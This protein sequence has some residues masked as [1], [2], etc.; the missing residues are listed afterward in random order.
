MSDTAIR[1]AASAAT[2]GLIALVLLTAGQIFWPNDA[3]GGPEAP[4]PAYQAGDLID[5]PAAWHDASP[6]TLMIFAQASCGACQAAKPY[7]NDLVAHL[8]GRA[9][10]ILATPGREAAWDTQY[11]TELGVSDDRRY[12]VPPGLRVRAT[13]TLVVVDQRG[14]ILGAWEGVGPP[15]EHPALTAAIDQIIG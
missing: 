7:L 12:V 2:V 14:E 13:P 6:Y 8:D 10:A 5:T 9:T 15:D 3:F 4:A 11:G 1:R